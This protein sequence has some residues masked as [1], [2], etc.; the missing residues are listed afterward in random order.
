MRCAFTAWFCVALFAACSCRHQQSTIPYSEPHPQPL[1]P[2]PGA[3][4]FRR[5]AVSI[6]VPTGI[7]AFRS[8]EKVGADPDFT[9]WHF[10][11]TGFE[12][13]HLTVGHKM[14]TGA[15]AEIIM[16][17]N[18]KVSAIWGGGSGTWGPHLPPSLPTPLPIHLLR[19]AGPGP[20]EC[21]ATV[22]ETDQQPGY[23]QD[24]E[25]GRYY[26]VLWTRTFDLALE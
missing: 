11:F 13:V 7:R 6:Q 19:N 8:G 2:V 20:C 18:G 14:L 4:P 9:E 26:R 1:P 22:F 5:H 24:P 15:K 21:R 25:G 10:A 17:R 12:T 16:R 3:D 23:H